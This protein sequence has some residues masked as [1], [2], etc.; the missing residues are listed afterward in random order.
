[1]PAAVRE[2]MAARQEQKVEALRYVMT[3][4]GRNQAE[5][6]K[7]LRASL[8]PWPRLYAAAASNCPCLNHLPAWYGVWF[9]N[10]QATSAMSM[11]PMKNPT[12]AE[13][14]MKIRVLPK[15]LQMIGDIPPALATAAP[16]RPPIS[17]CDDEEGMP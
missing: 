3:H 2:I 13:M 8:P 12:S 7:L 16:T 6:A 14:M 11:P 1:M 15:P 5:Q 9:R 10:S 4:L 17:A